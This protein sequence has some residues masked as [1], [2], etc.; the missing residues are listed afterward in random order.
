[1]SKG[2]LRNSSVMVGTAST[3]LR[4]IRRAAPDVYERFSE[5][6]SKIG[7]SGEARAVEKA[8]Y[9]NH[10][11]TDFS[12]DVLVKSAEKLF[13]VPVPDS[14]RSALSAKRTVHQAVPERIAAS[15]AR[16]YHPAQVGM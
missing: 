7:T 16:D 10:R 12:R 15:A 14:V 2:A 13:V 1:L 11:D 5:A 3:F 9:S 6:R 4:K 8:Y